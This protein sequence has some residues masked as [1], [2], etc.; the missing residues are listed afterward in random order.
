MRERIGRWRRLPERWLHGRR[1]AAARSGLRARGCPSSVLVVCHG[2]ICRSP[3][4]A[5][6]LST[7]LKDWGVTVSSAGFVGPGRPAPFMARRA[8]AA[9]GIELVRHRSRALTPAL[10][11]D[12]ALIVVMEPAQRTAL[13]RAYGAAARDV[14]VL[15]DF[16]PEPVEHRAIT[17][18]FDLPMDVYERVYAR[19]ERCARVLAETMTVPSLAPGRRPARTT[20]QHAPSLHG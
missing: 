12:A 6:V 14:V 19:I 3:F 1:R 11:R 8:A 16:D 20:T 10:V 9:R 17:D 2:N 15:G 4:A 5:A 13:R 7:A 18:P